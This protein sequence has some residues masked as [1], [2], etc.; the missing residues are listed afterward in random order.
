MERRVAA[1]PQRRH[2]DWPTADAARVRAAPQLLRLARRPTIICTPDELEYTRGKLHVGDFRVDLVYKR[3]HPEFLAHA[4]E[5][6]PLWR[7]TR[8][9]A[10]V[11]NP[12]RCKVL[13]RR[14][15]SS[16]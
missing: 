12:F 6:H 11:V 15:P 10:C 9:A 7:A 3:H 2:L 16:C 1:R 4:D 8:R 5:T 13:Q 14:P